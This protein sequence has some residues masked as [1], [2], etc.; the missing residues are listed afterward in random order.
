MQDIYVTKYATPK[1]ASLLITSTNYNTVVY[2]SLYV[3][4]ISELGDLVVTGAEVR[5]NYSV[6]L[7]M[8]P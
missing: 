3:K 8:H 5:N 6:T 4:K 1:T 2:L 7:V